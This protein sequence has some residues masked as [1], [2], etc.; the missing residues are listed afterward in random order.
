MQDK[1]FTLFKDF[2]FIVKSPGISKCKVIKKDLL[3]THLTATSYHE[4][5]DE[6]DGSLFCSSADNDF[7]EILK[8]YNSPVS[9]DC[10]AI[11][12]IDVSSM[13]F[14]WLAEEFLDELRGKFEE[15]EF[16]E[17]YFI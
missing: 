9:F 15:E 3:L 14:D 10:I 4:F 11:D 6:Y 2:T 7:E 5:F 17:L 13:N 12:R 1:T 16:Y 8:L